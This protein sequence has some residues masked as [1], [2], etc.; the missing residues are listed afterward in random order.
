MVN[1]YKD[2]KI[3]ENKVNKKQNNFKIK[4]DDI[5]QLFK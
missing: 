1:W 2:I 4:K 5:S 3:T